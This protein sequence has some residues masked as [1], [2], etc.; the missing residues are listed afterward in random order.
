[1]IISYAQNYEDVMLWRALKHVRN[2]FYIDVGANDPTIDSV[3]NLF[4]E[5]GWSGINIEP[6]EDHFI[7]LQSQRA[8]DINLQCAIGSTEG[9]IELWKCDIRGWATADREVIADHVAKG[10][11]GQYLKVPMTTLNKV[12]EQFASGDIHFL[13]ID[14]E[15]FERPA[16]EGLDLNLFRPW[17]VVV[18]ATR[19]NTVIEIHQQWEFL[20]LGANYDFVYADGLN[21]FYLSHEH[22]ELKSAFK[23]PPNFFDEFVKSPQI[24]GNVWA[25]AI[26][27]RVTQ[28]E[29]KVVQAN[30]QAL[31]AE[32]RVLSAEERVVN[33]ES[34]ALSAEER[35]VNAEKGIVSILSSSSWRITAPLRTVFMSLYAL[36]NIL[37]SLKSEQLIFSSLGYISSKP[38]LRRSGALVFARFPSIKMRIRKLISNATIEESSLENPLSNIAHLPARVRQIYVSLQEELLNLPSQAPKVSKRAKDQGLRLAYVSPLPPVRSGISDYSAELLPALASFYEID[39]IIEQAN[40]SDNLI[41]EHYGVRTVEWLIQN[42]NYYQRV[43]YHFGNSSY[44]Q[45]MFNLLLKIPGIVVLHDFYLGDV[46]NYLEAYAIDPFAY[47]RGL[48]SSH[49]YGALAEKFASGKLTEV[50][51]K[52]PANL[53]VLKMAQGVI[54][55]SQHSKNLANT[56]YGAHFSDN[57]SVIPIL[58]KLPPEF[59]HNEARKQLGLKP[60]DFLV[61]SFGFMGANKLNHRL[62]QAWLNSSMASNKCCKLVFV[63]VEQDG[64]YGM[65]LKQAISS[66]NLSNRIYITGWTDSATFIK[67]LSVANV[68]VQLRTDSRGESSAAVLDCMNFAIPTITNAHGAFVELPSESVFMLPEIFED[69]ELTDAL[70]MLWLD[71][72]SRSRIGLCGQQQILNHHRPELCAKQY[73][74]AI[75][76]GYKK[77]SVYSDEIARVIASLG[78]NVPADLELISLAQSISLAYPSN[79]TTRELFID[80]SATCRNDLKTGIQRVVRALVYALIQ[81]PPDGYRVEPVYLKNDNGVWHYCYARNWTFNALG[82][83]LGWMADE[84]IDYSIEDVLLIA[85]FTSGFAVEAAKDGVFKEMK[86]KGVKIHF[87]V[88][89]LLPILMPQHFPP[90]QFGFPEWL[91]SLTAIADSALCISRAVSNDLQSWVHTSGPQRITPLSIDWF[92][93]GADIVNSIPTAGFMTNSKKILSRLGAVPSFLMVGTIE[94]RKGYLQ[95]IQAFTELWSAGLNINLVIVGKEGWRGL[96]DNMRRTIPEIMNLLQSHPELG[97]RLLW[98]DDASDEYLQN[99]YASSTCL[100]VA[101]EGE[102]FG[103]PLIEAAQHG[104]PIIVRNLPVFRE[105]ASHHAYYF[106]GL[107]PQDLSE[108]ILDWI[109]LKNESV[110]PLSTEI[111][112]LSWTESAACVVKKLHLENEH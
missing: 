66:S 62:L 36:N 8:R 20:L 61:C 44:H 33:A 109:S 76:Q 93:L 28:A 59:N 12:C 104:L 42:P 65:A 41:T 45:H 43:I 21:R 90:E 108:A 103:L 102:G 6:I 25:E 77:T 55:H 74:H 18:E 7:A 23:Y 26:L 29:E 75:E 37:R 98:L 80:V 100:I 79:K 46:L 89:D 99:I 13:K 69:A 85:D 5:N 82:L 31:N 92:H 10:N 17:V 38:L 111:S 95:V 56:W 1:M 14:V 53:E 50:V 72:E 78:V 96:P 73:M 39:V 67:Y 71:D 81:S 84:P 22:L 83:A 97:K 54:V 91:S 106:D 60:N 57:W 94:P 9:N 101:S 35:A 3:T 47:N 112:W 87:F 86:A 34:R 64:D 49:G 105:V 16:L 107:N 110:Y 88:Y 58:R 30:A 11:V 24:E 15:G 52:Y 32:T 68:A 48:Y 4:Y 70:N 27:A 19:P 51:K 63:G 40:L 2:G